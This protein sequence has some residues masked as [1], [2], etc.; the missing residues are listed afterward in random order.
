LLKI[1]EKETSFESQEISD[2]FNKLF[3]S[4]GQNLANKV[5]QA[6]ND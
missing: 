1:N 4:I 5:N 2:H 6:Q 3:C